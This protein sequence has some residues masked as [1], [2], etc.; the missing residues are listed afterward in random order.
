MR[1]IA[2]L[3]SGRG[4]N[5]LAIA[6]AIDRGEIPGTKIAAVISDQPGA[7]GLARARQRGLPAWV[8]ER[9]K[10]MVREEHEREVRRILDAV[11]PDLVCLAGY[12]RL[13]SPAFVAAY[14]GRILNIHPA[15]LPKFPG[16]RAQRQ[17]LLAGEKVSGCTVHL[18]DEGV[19]TGPIILQR[20]VPILPGD[21]EESL[22]GRILEQE[23][24]AYPEAIRRVLF[25][26]S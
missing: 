23:H 15:L 13:L 19:D 8:V 12:M 25:G 17:A 9:P 10:S 6:E 11:R 3:L 21:T 20:E 16:L 26:P 2:V 7:P 18:V 5:F 24:R 22:A 1:K 14:R 4:S